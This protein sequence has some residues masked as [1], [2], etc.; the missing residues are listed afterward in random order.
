[1]TINCRSIP[2]PESFVKQFESRT[3]LVYTGKQRLA[4][5]TLI[6]ALRKCALTPVPRCFDDQK[7]RSVL[8][9]LTTEAQKAAQE[10]GNID[11]KDSEIEFV[12]LATVVSS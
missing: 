7:R 8:L 1:M 5:D 12:K 6:N 10:L 2:I 9:R 4:K 11:E 3:F